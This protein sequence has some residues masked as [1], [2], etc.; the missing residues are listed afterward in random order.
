[1]RPTG[2]RKLLQAT[3]PAPSLPRWTAETGRREI[4]CLVTFPFCSSGSEGAHSINAALTAI[5]PS[6]T[7]C[8]GDYHG[9]ARSLHRQ[10]RPWQIFRA[11]RRELPPPPRY[12]H[13]KMLGSSAPHFREP[14]CCPGWCFHAGRI[15]TIR[16]AGVWFPYPYAWRYQKIDYGLVNASRA[17]EMI[18]DG[19]LST[20]SA[21]L[22]N[23]C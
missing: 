7:N 14:G 9:Q 5:L 19:D 4:S 22:F 21:T 8:P 10:S 18:L 3:P 15:S 12:L 16:A 6:F 23:S 13:D 2:Q 11:P 20:K 17:A 1:M